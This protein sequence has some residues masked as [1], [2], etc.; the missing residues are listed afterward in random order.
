MHKPH[1]THPDHRIEVVKGKD[2]PVLRIDGVPVKYG[3]LPD[4]RYFLDDYA[5]DPSDDLEELARRYVEHRRK[6]DAIRQER[7]AAKGGN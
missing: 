4:G 3:R 2:K 5:Y 1:K 7:R 6:A